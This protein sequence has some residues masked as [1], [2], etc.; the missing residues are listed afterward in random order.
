MNRNFPNIDSILFNGWKKFMNRKVENR[1][2]LRAL[3]VSVGQQIHHNKVNL[4]NF[5]NISDL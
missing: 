5:Y 1:R 3:F 2:C 4:C